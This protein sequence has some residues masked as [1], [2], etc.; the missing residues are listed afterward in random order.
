MAAPLELAL[1]QYFELVQALFAQTK[2]ATEESTDLHLRRSTDQQLFSLVEAAEDQ[3]E[4]H[5]V[6]EATRDEFSADKMEK[7]IDGLWDSPV[8]SFF[9][10]SRIYQGVFR[11]ECIDDSSLLASFRE[12][13][14]RRTCQVTY[15]A[16]LEFIE[17]DQDA[18]DFGDFRIR[19]LNEVELDQL[20]KQD[21]RRVFY[22]GTVVDS[23]QL[24][25]YWFVEAT[26]MVSAGP[27]Q[28]LEASIGPDVTLQ[29]STF[30]KLLER[31][32]RRLVLYRFPNP[33][34]GSPPS[35][36]LK[37]PID[38]WSGFFR[39]AVPFV[40]R[41]SD[42][43]TEPPQAA[44]DVS[45]L[46]VEP[47]VVQST[48]GTLVQLERAPID[49]RMDAD[50]TAAFLSFIKK[51]NAL[52]GEI[53]PSMPEWRFIDVAMNFL[54]K[55]FFSDFSGGIEQLLWHIV[56]VEAT[57]GESGAGVT[58]RL[59]RRVSAILAH[60][61][62]E[63]KQIRDEFNKLYKLR[64]TLVHGSAKLGTKEVFLGHLGQAR[65]IA[66]R[67][68]CWMLCY[69]V[70]VRKTCPSSSVGL[71]TREDILLSLDMDDPSR[72]RLSTLLATLPEGFP[73][74]PDW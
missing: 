57:L 29:Y 26:E 36:G 69:L 23:R 47:D 64:N 34:H 21:V 68:V 16:S 9:R 52:L 73:H 5:A 70:H 53:E 13:L 40:I 74:I 35:V 4:F 37:E 54:V 61:E 71:P 28:G 46:T 18:L 7:T 20:L 58:E 25:G 67:V 48:D 17:F 45:D 39:F 15:L 3:P 60:S 1:K 11:G 65:E 41:V 50:E 8:Q 31:V 56:A 43:I 49:Y 2:R 27:L 66:R 42:A 19:C 14:Q 38:P 33:L 6:V 44:P 63:A 22:P 24:G 32:F 10:Q 55:A 72:A 12:A 62:D 59:K 30:P 51:V